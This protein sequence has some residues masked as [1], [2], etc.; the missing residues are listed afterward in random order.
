MEKKY[1]LIV[2]GAGVCGCVI[3]HLA[4]KLRK[5]V[6]IVERRNE[7][8]GYVHARDGMTYFHTDNKAI[9]AV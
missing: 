2:V 8:G 6:L 3:A 5:R 1:D 9:A 7:I 4:A